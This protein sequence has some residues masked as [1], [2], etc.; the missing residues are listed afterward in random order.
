VVSALAQASPAL[1]L[2]VG[3]STGQTARCENIVS[4]SCIHVRESAGEKNI[5]QN[6]KA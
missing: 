6:Q 1:L 5:K 4:N 3:A 2:P